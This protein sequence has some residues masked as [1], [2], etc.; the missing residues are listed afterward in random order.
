MCQRSGWGPALCPLLLG[1]LRSILFL[2]FERGS[3][4]R[5]TSD[6][7]LLHLVWVTIEV[8]LMDNPGS[9]RNVVPG[10]RSALFVVISWNR[11]GFSCNGKQ[12]SFWLALTV[13][14]WSRRRRRRVQYVLT[15]IPVI[16][17]N[18][19][20]LSKSFQGRLNDV[21]KSKRV[22]IIT[23]CSFLWQDAF[24]QARWMETYEENL[25]RR[26]RT[27]WCNTCT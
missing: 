16:K 9:K 19:K 21:D 25:S 23:H 7:H 10:L 3:A 12:R 11:S 14:C 24:F 6:S 22:I 4:L 13:T 26:G 17:P 8:G 1:A 18:K 20:V 2:C 5:W 27:H 15:S